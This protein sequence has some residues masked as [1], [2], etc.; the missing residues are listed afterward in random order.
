MSEFE[1]RLSIAKMLK[2]ADRINEILD[3]MKARELNLKNA[4]QKAA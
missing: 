3:E 4:Q 2:L 1:K